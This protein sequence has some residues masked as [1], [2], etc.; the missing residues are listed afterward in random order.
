MNKVAENIVYDLLKDE[1]GNEIAVASTGAAR[2]TYFA[3]PKNNAFGVEIRFSSSGAVDVKVDL[4]EGNVPP[5]TDK[6]SDAAWV[7]GDAISTGIVDTNTKILKVTPV[8]A[9]FG[10][11]LFTGQGSN[12]ASVKVISCKIVLSENS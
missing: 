3:L 9:K 6:A 5:A 2:T 12:H 11:I 1:T 8:V 4:E 7:I 10:R